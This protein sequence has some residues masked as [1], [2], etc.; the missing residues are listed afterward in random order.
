MRSLIAV[1][2]VLA[3]AR[4]AVAQSRPDL[5]DPVAFAETDLA[6]RRLA[7]KAFV[8]SGLAVGGIV[9]ASSLALA[10]GDPNHDTGRWLASV[11][12]GGFA[13]ALAALF[14]ATGIPMW[15]TANQDAAGTSRARLRDRLAVG[16]GLVGTG[17]VLQIASVPLGIFGFMAFLFDS[18]SSQGRGEAMSAAAATVGLTGLILMTTG[19]PILVTAKKGLRARAS[20]SLNAT[21]I[22]GT[23]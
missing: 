16:R 6:R 3:T 1:T 21:G 7:G 13:G 14:V 12:S 10:L 18:P 20:V 15:V 4:A 22:S 19:M 17:I 11:V 5:V 2:L 9:A 8:G 23:F